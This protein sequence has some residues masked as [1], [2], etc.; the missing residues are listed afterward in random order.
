LPEGPLP[1]PASL[2]WTGCSDARTTVTNDRIPDVTFADPWNHASVMTGDGYLPTIGPL[3]PPLDTFGG[4]LYARHF[5]VGVPVLDAATFSP[6]V[7]VHSDAPTVVVI[8]A[9]ANP[10]SSTCGDV[11]DATIGVEGHPEA[12]ITSH[13]IPPPPSGPYTIQRY[14]V[15]EGLPVGASITLT[16]TSPRCDV[17]IDKF[18]RVAPLQA[19]FV[20][21][22]VVDVFDPK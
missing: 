13:L 16:G 18:M 1:H 20:H 11:S 5:S 10:S 21:L 12:T 7:P 17:S 19:G 9:A 2:S 4:T 3:L 14:D 22:A 6:T 8:V 15:I